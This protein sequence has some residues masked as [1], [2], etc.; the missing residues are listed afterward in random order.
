MRHAWLWQQMRLEVL[1]VGQVLHWAHS[2]Q[3]VVREDVGGVADRRLHVD[4][5]QHYKQ[6][7]E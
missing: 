4:S 5:L 3:L 6:G 7:G 2:G 1:R